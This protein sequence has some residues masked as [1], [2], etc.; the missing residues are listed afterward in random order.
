M[1]HVTVD[2]HIRRTPDDVFASHR[3]YLEDCPL[4]SELE[5]PTSQRALSGGAAGD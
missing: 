3:R 5:L 2:T 4:V 1:A